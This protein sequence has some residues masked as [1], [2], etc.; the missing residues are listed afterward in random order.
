MPGILVR[1]RPVAFMEMIDSGDSDS[2]IIAVPI[3]D[4]RWEHVQGLEDVNKHTLK[5][6]EH[7]FSTYKKRGAG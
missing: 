4:P 2:K 3:D 6:M 7:Y 1:V 5:E